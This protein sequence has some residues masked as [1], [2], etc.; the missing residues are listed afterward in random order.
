[1]GKR[2]TQTRDLRALELRQNGHSFKVVADQMGYAS[3]SAAWKAVERAMNVTEVDA[4]RDV[5]RALEVARLD[6]LFQWLL[7]KARE[8]DLGAVDRLLKISS[9]RARLLNLNQSVN[10]GA[11][12]GDKVEGGAKVISMSEASDRIARLMRGEGGA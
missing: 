2:N 7:P 3:P 10:T 5:H 4:P 1:M 11:P 8:G 6:Q 9:Q 12:A